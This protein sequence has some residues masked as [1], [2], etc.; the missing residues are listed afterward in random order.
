MTIQFPNGKGLQ[1]TYPLLFLCHSH[2]CQAKEPPTV[3]WEIKTMTQ[4]LLGRT[5]PH[6]KNRLEPELP[7]ALP[8]KFPSPKHLL[9]TCFQVKF[10]GTLRLH[11]GSCQGNWIHLWYHML[12]FHMLIISISSFFSTH[13]HLKISIVLHG[14]I[15]TLALPFRTGNWI[16]YLN[17]SFSLSLS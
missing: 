10:S 11:S 14:L 9:P 17:P 2:L 6:R 4:S 12:A 7:T 1:Q 16:Y 15:T 5:K 13:I 8:Q 3:P